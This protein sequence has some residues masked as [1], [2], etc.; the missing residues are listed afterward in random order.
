M[1]FGYAKIANVPV[2]NL[3]HDERDLWLVE[4]RA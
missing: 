2:E 4:Q 3:L 1:L